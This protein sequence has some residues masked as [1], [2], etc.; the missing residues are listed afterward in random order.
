MESSIELNHLEEVLNKMKLLNINEAYPHFGKKGI[1]LY[2]MPCQKAN[3]LFTRKE[4]EKVIEMRK[5]K[6]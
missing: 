2:L 4:L 3:F 6:N 5:T 1:V